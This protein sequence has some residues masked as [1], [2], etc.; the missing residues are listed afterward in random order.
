MPAIR[1]R[2]LFG[3]G[4]RINIAHEASGYNRSRSRIQAIRIRNPSRPAARGFPDDSPGRACPGQC[5]HRAK[6]AGGLLRVATPGRGRQHV[7]AARPSL[8]ESP[9]GVGNSVANSNHSHLLSA[10]DSTELAAPCT[11]VSAIASPTGSSSKRPPRSLPNRR[12]EHPLRS[13]SGSP[14][15]SARVSDAVRAGNSPW[16]SS[17]GRRH[18]GTWSCCPTALR[19]HP[20]SKSRWPSR[21]ASRSSALLLATMRPWRL[22]ET[23]EDFTAGDRTLPGTSPPP[24]PLSAGPAVLMSTS[25]GVRPMIVATAPGT[26]LDGKSP[27]PAGNRPGWGRSVS[28]S[29]T[30]CSSRCPS[31]R[32]ARGWFRASPHGTPRT[33]ESRRTTPA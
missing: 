13:R 6:R 4:M 17:S 7:P 23:D 21:V 29:G 22:G 10:P 31:S 18:S 20:D 27:V 2:R 19:L 1:A 26:V 3:R 11:S 33:S 5:R 8:E 14:T 30:G 16:I 24:R 32:S 12:R 15:G 28:R 25:P 9:T